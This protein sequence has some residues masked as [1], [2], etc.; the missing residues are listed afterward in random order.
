MISHKIYQFYCKRN[1]EIVGGITVLVALILMGIIVPTIT[2]LT[3]QAIPDT[4]W[5]YSEQ[6]LRDQ[7]A[8]LTQGNGVLY[9]M[10]LSTDTFFPFLYTFLVALAMVPLQLGIF[11]TESRWHNLVLL[12]FVAAILDY[13]ENVL[14]FSQFISYPNLNA[15]IIA[16]ASVVTQLKWITIAGLLLLLLFE[17]VAFL[18]IGI[19]EESLD[20]SA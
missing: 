3:G 9:Y 4:S 20:T 13:A 10:L 12:P 14:I 2:G 16:I 1:L 8:L 17:G 15:G 18:F 7:F 19:K 6:N 5:G 11:K